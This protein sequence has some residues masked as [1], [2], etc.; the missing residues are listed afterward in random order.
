MMAIGLFASWLG[1]LCWNE[2]SQRLPTAIV[3]QLIVFETL[4]AL[5]YAFA[6]RG[7][8]PPLVTLAGIALLIFGVIWALRLQP[9]PLREASPGVPHRRWVRP[10]S[11][12]GR[13]RLRNARGT[14]Y[15][16]IGRPPRLARAARGWCRARLQRRCHRAD[17]LFGKTV[18]QLIP[19]APAAGG[20]TRAPPGE[21]SVARCNAAAWRLTIV[22]LAP[23]V[24][25]HTLAGAAVMFG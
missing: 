24:D 13:P 21:D 16:P 22:N 14:R 25:R 2:A 12:A 1:T 11:P 20:R 18:V 9:E 17:V 5:A 4:A 6:L 19:I 10:A 23:G 15:R 7:A 3:G 8:A